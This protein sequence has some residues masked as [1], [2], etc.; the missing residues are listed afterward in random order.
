VVD[1]SVSGR[2]LMNMSDLGVT[3]IKSYI[4]AVLVFFTGKLGV[5]AK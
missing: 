4:T 5:Q 3:N 1:N 2:S